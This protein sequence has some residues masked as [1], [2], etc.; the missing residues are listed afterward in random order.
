MLDAVEPMRA[1]VTVH[2]SHETL[3]AGLQ[4]NG[5]EPIA[6]SVTLSPAQPYKLSRTTS[7]EHW[8]LAQF[9]HTI[10]KN[11]IQL[12]MPKVREYFHATLFSM[13]KRFALKST[14]IPNVGW[15]EL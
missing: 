13:S 11:A 9:P 4:L 14:Y 3:A 2:V 6:S 5:P 15:D 1:R 8:A 10:A 12:R 7:T